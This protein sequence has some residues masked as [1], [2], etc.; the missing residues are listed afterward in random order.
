ME[1]M[2]SHTARDNLEDI[3]TKLCVCYY[4]SLLAFT[5]INDF[6]REEVLQSFPEFTILQGG[7]FLHS[8][9]CRSEPV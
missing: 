7:N 8:G 5:L 2:V 4:E 6:L 9:R 1:K 3:R